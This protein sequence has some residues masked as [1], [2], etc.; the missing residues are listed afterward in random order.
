VRDSENEQALWYLVKEPEQ[1]PS[2]RVL[3]HKNG[4]AHN[5]D[6]AIR[7]AGDPDRLRP[8]VKTHKSSAVTAVHLSRGITAYKCATTAEAEMLGAAGCPDVLLAYQPLGPALEELLSV[9]RRY[10][11]TSFSCLLDNLSTFRAVDAACERRGV[12]VGAFVDLD[13]GMHRTGIRTGDSAFALY[14]SIAESRWLVARGIHA[15][16]GHIHETDVADRCRQAA[17][18]R[19]TAI[20]LRARLLS[21]G[22]DVPEIVLGGTPSFPCHAQA[23]D[24]GIR[25][26]PGTYVYSDWGYATQHPD[27]PFEPAAVVLGRVIATDGRRHFT[28]DV[29]SKAIASDKPQPRGL[30]LNYPSAVALNQSEEHWVFSLEGPSRPSVGSLVYIWPRHICPTIEHYDEVI[31]M[32]DAGTVIDRWAVDARS[33]AVRSS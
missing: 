19:G 16:D 28:V 9:A 21:L 13:V 5:I 11:N 8:H 29:G 3:V 1:I 25:F 33:R 10:S 31:V 20:E 27:L 17:E 15:Y 26:S 30:V 24:W 12:A 4:V 32:S 2:P 22:L 14:R 7:I 23:M 18:A 6:A